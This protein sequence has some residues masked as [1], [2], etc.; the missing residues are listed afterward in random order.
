MPNRPR[1][2]VETALWLNDRGFW[3]VP[4]NGKRPVVSEW[5]KRK[6]SATKLIDALEGTGCNIA[7]VV[8]QSALVDVECDS[9]EAESRLQELC[10]GEIPPTPTWQSARGK[11]RLFLRPSGLPSKAV[12]VLDGIEFHVGN[13]KGALSTVPPSV[14]ESGVRYRWLPGLSLDDVEPAELPPAIVERLQAVVPVAP[15]ADGDIPEGQRNRTLFKLA[16]KLRDAGLSAESVERALLAENAARCKPP[17]PE[18]DVRGAVRSAMKGD[19]QSTQSSQTAAQILL[20]VATEDS[21]QWCAANGVPYATLRRDGHHEHWPVNSRQFR[22]WLGKE[23]Y[24]RKKSVVGSQTMQD[25]INVLGGKA[26]FGGLTYPLFVRVAG[27]EERIYLDLVDEAWRAIEVDKAGWRIV[28]NPPVRFRRAKAMLPLPVPVKGGSVA[29]LRRF[30]NVIDEHWPLLLAWL[31]ATF[32][33]TGPYTILK[34]LGEQGSAKTTTAKAVR[35]LNDPN[36]AAVRSAPR[37]ER[38]LVISASNSWVAAFDNLSWVESDMSDAYCRL[39]SG[40]GFSTRMLYEN[41]EEMVFDAQRPVILNGIEDVGFRSDLLDRSVIVELPRI[42][43]AQR[44]SES[45]FWREFEEARPRILGALLDAVSAAL[46]NFPAV[47]QSKT[48]WPR[49]ADFAMWAVAAEEALGLPAGSFLEAYAWNRETANEV[50]LDSSAVVTALRALLGRYGDFEGTATELLAKLS[51]GVDTR[52]RGWP[53]NSR[54]LAG[55]LTRLAPNLRQ[56]GIE[57]EQDRAQNRKLWH[58]R[59]TQSTQS[60][61][62]SG[63]KL[64]GV[65]NGTATKE[66]TALGI[67]LGKRLGRRA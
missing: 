2:L 1:N 49:M 6:L 23:F 11:H 19:S 36:S 5:D 16:C 62:K 39:V 63:T 15:N 51:S 57:I 65:G 12:Q 17:L 61:Q 59:S 40:G 32:R 48:K 35:A 29:E 56:A 60:S 38:D 13:G 4:C 64:K 14:H 50:A 21:E 54:V 18:N 45:V 10:G 20:A 9:P 58:I 22:Q 46:R 34:L 26:K 8:S 55:V 7:I 24:D 33:P 28:E 42:E 53:K 66:K 3:V 30:V 43:A 25:V 41:D 47:E 31:I 37:S 27:H 44:R 67:Y 52:E